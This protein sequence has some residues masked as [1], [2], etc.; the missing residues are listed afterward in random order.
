MNLGEKLLMVIVGTA[1]ALGIPWLAKTR[2]QIQTD[3]EIAAARAARA[4]D[5]QQ[6][7]AVDEQSGFT[8]IDGGSSGIAIYRDNKTG[9]EWIKAEGQNLRERTVPNAQGVSR[10]ICGEKK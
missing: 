8:R 6:G 2:A 7:K 5:A 10:Q 4:E 9:C 3:A 1:L